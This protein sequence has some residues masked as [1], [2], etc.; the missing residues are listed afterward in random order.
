MVDDKQ[1]RAEAKDKRLAG[2]K[3]KKRGGKGKKDIQ[4]D[5]E[6]QIEDGDD[7]M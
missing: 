2:A 7:E 5:D 6:F 1:K 3:G 4:S